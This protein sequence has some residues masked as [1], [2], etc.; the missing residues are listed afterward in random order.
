VLVGGKMKSFAGGVELRLTLEGLHLVCAGAR[1]AEGVRVRLK[2]FRARTF[3]ELEAGFL[4]LPWPAYLAQGATVNARVTCE[5]SRLW[6]SG[7]VRERLEGTLAS[8][9][10]AKLMQ[11]VED[12]DESLLSETE[13]ELDPEP[14]LGRELELHPEPELDPCLERDREAPKE[15]AGLRVFVRLHEDE[16]QVSIDAGGER[17]HRRGYRKMSEKASLRETLASAMLRAISGP[18][19]PEGTLWDPFCGAGTIPLEA[20][21]HSRGGVAQSGRSFA[22]EQW[23]G[24]SGAR[25]AELRQAAERRALELVPPTRLRVIGSDIAERAVRSSRTNLRSL[26]TLFHFDAE[27]RAQFLQGDVLE[28][29]AEVPEGAFILTNPPYGHRLDADDTLAKVTRLLERR[30]D[31]RPC[32]LLVGAQLKRELSSAF[33]VAFQTQNGGLNVALRVLG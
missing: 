13:L 30:Q 2:S 10:G 18:K 27:G 31:L 20:L 16:V 24:L 9:F 7:A 6:H 12:E 19:G 32:A 8:R 15:H 29:A 22:F 21:A 26:E 11:R 17:L 4:R 3:A 33:R 23:P 14:Q 5:R 28:V 25:H 1:L